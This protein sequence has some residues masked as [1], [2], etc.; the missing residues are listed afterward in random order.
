[1]ANY[2]TFMEALMAAKPASLKQEFISGITINA[3]MGPGIKIK[4]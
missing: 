4:N 2:K 3:T 1:M